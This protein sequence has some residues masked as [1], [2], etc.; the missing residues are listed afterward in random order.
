MTPMHSAP[1]L[2]HLYQRHH[3]MVTTNIPCNYTCMQ[4]C[5]FLINYIS[6]IN[7]TPLAI[8]HAGLLIL[9]HL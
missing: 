5:F 1:R 6:A 9:Y 8:S 7:V 4:A 3:R 2:Y